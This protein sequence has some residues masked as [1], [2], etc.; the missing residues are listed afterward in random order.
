[1]NKP[2]INITPLI[3]VLLVL[4]VIFMVITPLKPSSFKTNIPSPPNNLSPARPD[5]D[6]L[7]VSI[8]VN[9][10]LALNNEADLGTTDDPA[11]LVE[12]MSL[13]NGL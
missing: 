10:S 7:I 12:R 9:S 5:P 13:T 2:H 11:K 1:M 3:D 6:T 8:G 4:L